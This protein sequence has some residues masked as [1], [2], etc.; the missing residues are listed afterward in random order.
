VQASA[1]LRATLVLEHICTKPQRK[2][3]DCSLVVISDDWI[4]VA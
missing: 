2:R 4:A 3:G 1:M